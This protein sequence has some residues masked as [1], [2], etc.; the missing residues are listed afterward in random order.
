MKT[1]S[2]IEEMRR[3]AVIATSENMIGFCEGGFP[4]TGGAACEFC[5]AT[6]KDNCGRKNRAISTSNHAEPK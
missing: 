1:E 6:W 2:H 3:A 4:L 5:G